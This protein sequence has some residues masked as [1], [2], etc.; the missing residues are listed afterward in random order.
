MS[1]GI[2]SLYI[3]T[4]TMII[5]NNQPLTTEE[6][7]WHLYL[8]TME[9][10]IK[11]LSFFSSAEANKERLQPIATRV[12]WSLDKRGAS[13][14]YAFGDGFCLDPLAEFDNDAKRQL[15]PHLEERCLHVGISLGDAA[16]LLDNMF[17]VADSLAY[18]ETQFDPPIKMFLVSVFGVRA[19]HQG[20]ELRYVDMGRL[21]EKLEIYFGKDLIQ[22]SREKLVAALERAVKENFWGDTSIQ[23]IQTY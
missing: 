13:P 22:G 5:V 18:S 19:I 17:T 21:H 16:E 23:V 6:V 1:G 9:S 14:V 4:K 20:Y 2:Y 7:F 15:L 11:M 12:F 3:E 8:E 10:P